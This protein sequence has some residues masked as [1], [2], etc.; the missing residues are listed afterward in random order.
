[1]ARTYRARNVKE[2]VQQ[3]VAWCREHS[4]TALPVVVRWQPSLPCRSYAE[5]TRDSRR[6]YVTLSFS[7][8]RGSWVL[9][10]DTVLHEWAHCATW[11]DH[12]PGH[13]PEFWAEYGRLYALWCDGDGAD[14][15]KL[16]PIR[17][18]RIR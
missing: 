18:V 2:R 11:L 17:R 1:M 3:T 14:E 4:P 13:P 15:A 9:A 8:L 7:R 12:R 10:N 5:T 6:F 16:Y